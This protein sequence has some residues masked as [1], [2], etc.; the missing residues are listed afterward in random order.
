VKLGTYR[1]VVQ[2]G[3]GG[4]DFLEL[5]VAN[6]FGGGGVGGSDDRRGWFLDLAVPEE[7]IF[8]VLAIREEVVM[9]RRRAWAVSG[10]GGSTAVRHVTGKEGDDSKSRRER[11]EVFLWGVM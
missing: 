3:A 7:A 2:D 4:G 11:N 5:H 10:G 1:R 6:L 8:L 9:R